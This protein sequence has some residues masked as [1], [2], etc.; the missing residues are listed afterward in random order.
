MPLRPGDPSPL[1]RHAGPP[2][3]LH[4]RIGCEKGGYWINS[5]T[6]AGRKGS[7]AFQYPASIRLQRS[8]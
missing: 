6:A 3:F 1:P 8:G 5:K 2:G 4:R 7:W